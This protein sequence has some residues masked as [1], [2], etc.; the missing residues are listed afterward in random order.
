MRGDRRHELAVRHAPGMTALL[1]S[2]DEDHQFR[3]F[4]REYGAFAPLFD[5]VNGF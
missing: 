3:G 2:R 4:G 5:I 1:L